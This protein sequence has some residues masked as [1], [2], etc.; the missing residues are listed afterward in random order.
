M[1]QLSYYFVV[2]DKQDY[3]C[4]FPFS[5]HFSEL[6]WPD[7]SLSATSHLTYVIRLFTILNL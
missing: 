1:K 6:L 2:T 4:R 5:P 7:F 3:S